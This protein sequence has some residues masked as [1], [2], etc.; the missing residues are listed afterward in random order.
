[1][2]GNVPFLFPFFWGGE[3]EEG[4]H[5]AAL[6][7]Q[8]FALDQVGLELRDSPASASGMLGLK[9]PTPTSMRVNVLW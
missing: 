2:I 8:E 1:M 7:V 9:V 6:A 4:Y 5:C 3:G